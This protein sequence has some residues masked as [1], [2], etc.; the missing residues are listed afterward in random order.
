MVPE[1]FIIPNFYYCKN[2]L[3]PHKI[4]ISALLN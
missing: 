1:V 4:Y 2:I 3:K